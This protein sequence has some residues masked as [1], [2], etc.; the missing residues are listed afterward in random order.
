MTY[1]EKLK[2]PRW[3]KKR[4]EILN[5]D[6]WSCQFCGNTKSTLHVHH[7]AYQGNNPWETD[8]DLLEVLCEDCHDIESRLTP[9]ESFLWGC[10]RQ[11]DE[12]NP[13]FLTMS[14]R[15]IKSYITNRVHGQK[16]Y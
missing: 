2:D 7:K 15:I 9:L 16:I 5:R 3:Q 1:A 12:D 14:K 10:L 11:R 6:G 8:D 4:L 13:E